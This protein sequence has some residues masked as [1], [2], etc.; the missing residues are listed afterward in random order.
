MATGDTQQAQ[1]TQ[2]QRA[3]SVPRNK[4]EVT[5]GGKDYFV[6]ELTP[7]NIIT[8]FFELSKSISKKQTETTDKA[9]TGKK[10]TKQDVVETNMDEFKR[11]IEDFLSVATTI[12]IDEIRELPFSEIKRLKDAFTEVNAD[13]L[14][15]IEWAGMTELV[16]A[17]GKDLKAIILRDLSGAL[18]NSFKQ[19]T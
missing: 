17:V 4:A 16:N 12:S 3:P 14:D 6:Y 2:T 18:S 19:G 13:F 10:T 11:R 9:K 5:L 15:V 7:N 1:G 8:L